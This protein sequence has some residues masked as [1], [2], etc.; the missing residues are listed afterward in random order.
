MADSTKWKLTSQDDGKIIEG[1][2]IATDIVKDVGA[3]YA[4][5]ATFG[6]SQPILQYQ[7]DE[8]EKLNFTA[9][10]WATHQGDADGANPDTIEALVAD[11]ENLPRADPDLGR[12]KI[13]EFTAGESLSMVCVVKTVGGVRY[14]RMRPSD[15]SLRGATFKISLWRFDEYD[16]SLSGNA[17]E[18]LVLAFKENEGFESLARRVY[19]DPNVGEPLRRRNPELVIP[20]AGDLVHLPPKSSLTVGFTLSPASVPLEQTDRQQIAQKEHFSRR[21]ARYRSHTL[22]P[23]WSEA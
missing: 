14:D 17:A 5:I 7:N 15:G 18:S 13:W 2:F 4:E 23:E 1:Q 8:L 19:G 20:T 21:G 3:N 12:P 10:V 6:R 22:G 9:R 16:V 11:I